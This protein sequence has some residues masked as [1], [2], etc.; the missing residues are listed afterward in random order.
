ML[1]R[2][3]KFFMDV[4]LGEK[5]RMAAQFIKLTKQQIE[6][7]QKQNCHCGDWAQ[8]LVVPD[9]KSDTIINTTFSGKIKLGKFDKQIN[10]YGGVTKPAGIY[11]AHLHNCVIGNNV[12]ISN[13]TNY[14]AN[15]IIEDGCIIDHID[16][17][18]VEGRTSFGNGTKAVVINEAGGRE[19]PIFDG[20]T[21]QIAYI[22]AL[23]RHRTSVRQKLEHLISQYVTS[24]TSDTG[25]VGK[26]AHLSNCGTIKNVKIGPAAVIGN[27]KRLENG[28]IKSCAEDPTEIGAGVIAKD[29]IIAQGAKINEGSIISNCFIGQATKMTKQFSAENSVC[30][31]N[32]GFHHGEICSI[33]AGPYTVSHHKSTLLIAGLF[34]FF[35]AGSG[36]NESN[37]MYKVGAV[38][39]G[40]FE[41]GSKMTSNGYIMYPVWIG[42]FSVILGQHY[43]NPQTP[44][45]PFSYL[46]EE[47][48]KT[49]V[50]PGINLRTVGTVRDGEKW[51][52]RDERKAPQKMDLIVFDVLSPYTV[53]KIIK[54]L[55]I[56]LNLKPSS[57]EA[58]YNGMHFRSSSL[59]KGIEYYTLAI[60]KFL[61]DCLIEK[62][63]TSSL[64]SSADAAK[65][66][67]TV[68]TSGTGKWLD[69]V[70]LLTPEKCIN[71]LLDDI[72]SEKLNTL[73]SIAERLKQFYD[74]YS[75]YKWSWAAE[76]IGNIMRSQQNLSQSEKMIKIIKDWAD[77]CEKLTALILED[78]GK[79]FTDEP[80]VG[81]G[82]DGDKKTRDEDFEAVRGTFEGNDFVRQLK[83]QNEVT[84][85]TAEEMIKKIKS[86][87]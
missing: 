48:G 44:D 8:V 54:G 78:A 13:V 6:Q 65:L 46:F 26:G 5:K 14:I 17:L 21:A 3:K 77:A 66:L 62:L 32:C 10:F 68:N 70:G 83:Q 82:I 71:S 31:A 49:F 35:N 7:L 30:F 37:H 69:L 76:K 86:L 55:D 38:H 64:N 53:Q 72:E 33:F 57:D 39:Q 36:S 41:R 29:F 28:T 24:V 43:A 15:Y 20:L 47:D 22:I 23:Y 34:S 9:F 59:Q 61:G 40:I 51:P 27:A 50:V 18:A 19:I 4:C 60:N 80:R 84:K 73:E 74:N 1:I 12:Y 67:E 81:F 87:R 85:K 79:E 42:A 45:M 63:R 75:E 16:L 56:L 58:V 2:L 52:K 11:N 25:V